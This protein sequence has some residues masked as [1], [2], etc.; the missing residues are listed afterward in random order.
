LPPQF[1]F[2]YMSPGLDSKG[3]RG[4]SCSARHALIFSSAAAVTVL[5]L[6]IKGE[7]GL[8]AD[9]RGAAKRT[10]KRTWTEKSP[11][12]AGVGGLG[13]ELWEACD[14]VILR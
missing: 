13:D 10:R 7:D 9:A 11:N 5:V 2:M 4:G 12:N 6:A 8:P 1:K 3:G 14:P